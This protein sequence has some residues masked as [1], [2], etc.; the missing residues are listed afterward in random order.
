MGFLV[1]AT[2]PQHADFRGEL[3]ELAVIGAEFRVAQCRTEEE[4]RRRCART[5]VQAL[6]GEMP[7]SLVNP[8]VL[9][10]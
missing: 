6:R 9:T 8:E 2:D 4:L 3:E 1:V 5:V 10:R 7:A